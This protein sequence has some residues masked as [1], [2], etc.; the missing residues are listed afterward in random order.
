MN[1]NK[2]IKVP[3]SVALARINLKVRLDLLPLQVDAAIQRLIDGTASD[4]D[5]AI[6]AME[7]R[8]AERMAR[9]GVGS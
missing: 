1:A 3:V 2:T 7:Q 6:V 5:A 8:K 9:G 4:A